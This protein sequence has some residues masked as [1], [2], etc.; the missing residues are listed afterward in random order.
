MIIT[1]RAVI[2]KK[3]K[4]KKGEVKVRQDCHNNA[5]VLKGSTTINL[6]LKLNLK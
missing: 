5:N 4:K 6:T 2:A 1:T 3:Y